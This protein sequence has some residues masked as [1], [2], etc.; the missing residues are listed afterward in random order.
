MNKCV[1]FNGTVTCNVTSNFNCSIQRVSSVS[2]TSRAV[3]TTTTTRPP[4][5]P[6]TTTTT[7]GPPPRPVT[8]S[9]TRPPARTVTTATTTSTTTTI[10]PFAKMCE[11]AGIELPGVLPDQVGCNR[12]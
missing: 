3:T 7:T 8:T 4:P 11:A 5:R 9:T 2:W 6:V 12:Q 1:P 10:S